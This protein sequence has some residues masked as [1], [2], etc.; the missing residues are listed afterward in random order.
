[1]LEA[2]TASRALVVIGADPGKLPIR[3]TVETPT[4]DGM[5]GVTVRP[6]VVIGV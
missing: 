3:A 6:I 2:M 4:S 5:I 1:M